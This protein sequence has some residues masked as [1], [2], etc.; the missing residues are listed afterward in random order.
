MNSRKILSPFP[1]WWINRMTCLSTGRWWHILRRVIASSSFDSLQSNA[2]LTAYK[3]FL[4][5]K[6][7]KGETGNKRNL[8][9]TERWCIISIAILIFGFFIVS[10]SATRRSY[11]FLTLAI[12]GW[13]F[14]NATVCPNLMA[15]STTADFFSRVCS[16]LVDRIWFS[17]HFRYS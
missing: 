6:E 15:C 4:T 13:A 14:S 5:R 8:G 2:Y 1:H 3:C 10:C 7:M 9:F 11:G 17:E 16:F 12:I